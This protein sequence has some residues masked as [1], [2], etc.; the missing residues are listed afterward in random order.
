MVRYF[1]TTGIYDGSD[2]LRIE[3]MYEKGKGYVARVTPCHKDDLG[4]GVCYCYE[5]Y[6]YYGTLT[7]L[8][9]SCGRRSTKKE[10]EA[11]ELAN[12]NMGWILEQYV[13]MAENRGGRHIEI[14]GEVED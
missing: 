11:C 7:C 13:T 9:V 10:A 3:V 6:Q 1:Q 8:L 5:Y 2:M 4:W 14:V 12:K